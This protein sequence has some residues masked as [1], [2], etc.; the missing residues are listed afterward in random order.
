M[1][2]QHDSVLLC[3]N[4]G[5]IGLNWSLLGENGYFLAACQ[6]RPSES[7]VFAVFRVEPSKKT[8]PLGSICSGVLSVL[9][10]EGLAW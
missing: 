6:K 4:E 7:L 5:E 8:A 3:V 10:S 1:V 2:E 9:C